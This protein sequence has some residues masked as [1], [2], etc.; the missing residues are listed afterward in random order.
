MYTTKINT[1]VP[2]LLSLSAK[3]CNPQIIKK[4]NSLEFICKTYIIVWLMGNSNADDNPI[5]SR[6]LL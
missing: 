3:Y 5:P 2:G 6:H 4:G 1:E